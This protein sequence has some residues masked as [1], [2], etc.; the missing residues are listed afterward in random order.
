MDVSWARDLARR[1][2]EAPLPR[3]WAHSQG[4]AARAERLAPVLGEDAELLLCAAWLHDVGYS[5]DLA[6]TGFHPLDGARYLRDVQR[7]DARLCNLVAHHSCALLEAEERGLNGELNR[8][9][10][11]EAQPLVEALTH[12]DMTTTPDGQ[13]TT[14]DERIDEIIKRYG[15]DDLV[16]RFIQRAAPIIREASH[17]VRDRLE[18]RS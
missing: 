6:E 1:L 15:P 3:R 11:L 17:A 13:E 9:F 5:P 18:A 12:C 4:V 14:A 10:E 2:L 16:T 8:E 7:A